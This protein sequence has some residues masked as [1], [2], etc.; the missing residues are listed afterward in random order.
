MDHNSSTVTQ[1]GWSVPE[2]TAAHLAHWIALAA[3]GW[4]K[5]WLLIWLCVAD[6]ASRHKN[7]SCQVELLHHLCLHW[8]IAQLLYIIVLDRITQ[9][10]EVK[11]W[12]LSGQ[13][14]NTL[15]LNHLFSK[16]FLISFKAFSEN[17]A[18][19]WGSINITPDYSL[20]YH[21]IAEDNRIRGYCV[22]NNDGS[23]WWSIWGNN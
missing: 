22:I 6:W 17:F 9:Y 12:K 10:C 1:D 3:G 15:F 20:K 23:R 13:K 4:G 16:G 2:A 5:L 19:G 7:F 18:T 11:T 21:V 14:P 8:S